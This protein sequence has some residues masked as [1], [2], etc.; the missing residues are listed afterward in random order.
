M[1]LVCAPS[2]TTTMS[3]CSFYERHRGIKPAGRLPLLLGLLVLWARSSSCE[4]TVFHEKVSGSVGAG[5]YS[6]Y[7]LSKPGAVTI[8]VHPLSGDPDL[9][10]AERNVQ[11]TFDLDNHCLQSTTCGHER[12]ELPRHFGRP[13]GIGIYGHP[14]HALSIYELE[15]RVDDSIE[16]LHFFDYSYT[17]SHQPD[18]FDHFHERPT[19]AE[20]EVVDEDSDGSSE[21]ISL[22]WTFLLGLLK[23]LFEILQ[24]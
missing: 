19:P 12:V 23:I 21:E 8:L 17:E 9:Y 16:N 20:E 18:N 24:G 13:V 6:Y 15:V 3:G 5:N 2:A 14:S 4:T 1:T 22:L 10:V 7:T 11:P